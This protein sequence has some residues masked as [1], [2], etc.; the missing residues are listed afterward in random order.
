MAKFYDGIEQGTRESLDTEIDG[1]EKAILHEDEIPAMGIGDGD[2]PYRIKEG[3]FPDDGEREPAVPSEE[4]FDL[5][6]GGRLS[7][8]GRLADQHAQLSLLLDGTEKADVVSE[9]LI[10]QQPALQIGDR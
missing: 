6:D 5:C 1:G 7:G 10:V 9:Q 3:D 2:V 4:G 8:D